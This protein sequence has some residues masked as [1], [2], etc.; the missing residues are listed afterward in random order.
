MRNPFVNHFGTL[1]SHSGDQTRVENYF[2]LF[3]YLTM[4]NKNDDTK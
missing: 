2:S 4:N 3:G 1:R